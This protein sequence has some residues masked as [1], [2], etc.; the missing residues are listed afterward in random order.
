MP[1]ETSVMSRGCYVCNL[2][3]MELRLFSRDKIISLSLDL[4]RMTNT[5]T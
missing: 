5:F 1:P 2:I 3:S 4:W